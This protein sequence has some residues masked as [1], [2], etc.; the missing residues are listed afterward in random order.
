MHEKLTT[1]DTSSYIRRNMQV[2][3]EDNGYIILFAGDVHRPAVA[4]IQ[5]ENE[6]EQA[7]AR[8]LGK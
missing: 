1:T 8:F 3:Y 7:R 2:A 5:G 6:L 4:Q